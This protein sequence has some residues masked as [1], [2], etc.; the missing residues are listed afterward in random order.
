MKD[1]FFKFINSVEFLTG[2]WY[3]AIVVTLLNKLLE[4]FFDI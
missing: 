3:G 4:W 2:M 1:K